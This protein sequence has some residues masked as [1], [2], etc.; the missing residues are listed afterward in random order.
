MSL[1]VFPLHAVRGVVGLQGSYGTPSCHGPTGPSRAAAIRS[2]PASGPCTTGRPHTPARR[3][4]PAI[5]IVRQTAPDYRYPFKNSFSAANNSNVIFLIS[6]GE[7]TAA[8]KGSS[9]SA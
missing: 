4:A 6:A 7:Q 8:V 2:G 1:F 5:L 3:I 9:I